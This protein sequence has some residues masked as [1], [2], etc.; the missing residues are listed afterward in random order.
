MGRT[1]WGSTVDGVG[2]LGRV[3]LGWVG[4]DWDGYWSCVCEVSCGQAS[5]ARMGY[6]QRVIGVSDVGKRRTLYKMRGMLKNGSH[7]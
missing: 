4:L 6:R 7:V 2:W 3:G 5:V 1:C